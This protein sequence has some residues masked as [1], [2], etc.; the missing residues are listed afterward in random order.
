MA[1]QGVG[2][3]RRRT[4]AVAL[5]GVLGCGGAAAQ[6]VQLPEVTVNA[7]AAPETGGGPADGYVAH[8]SVAGTKTDTPLLET[9]QAISVVT[10]RQMDAQAVQTVDQALRYVPG[11]YSQDNDLRFEQVSIRGF[12]ADSYLDGL[13]LNHTTW[14]ATP[15]I[16]PWFLERIDVLHGPTSVLYGQGSPGGVIDMVSKLPTA[17]PLHVIEMG[18]GNHDRYQTGFD[19]GGPVD[20]DGK[21]LYRLT[22]LARD[23]NTQTDH[24]KEERYAIAPSLTW[25]PGADTSLTFLANYQNDPDGGLFNPVPAAGTVTHNPNGDLRPRQYL[26]DP[27]SDFFHRKQYSVGYQFQH[28]FNDHLQVRQNLRFLQDD[29][30]YYQ[31]SVTGPLAADFRTAPMW[32]NNNREQLRQFALD[33][34]AQFD[35]GTGPVQHTVLAGFDY[36]RLMQHI[37]RSGQLAGG[38]DVY[39]P[40]FSGFPHVPANIDQVTGQTQLG[41]Y[42]QDQLKLG[43]WALTVG[44]RRDW[45]RADD[46]Q[47]DAVTGA[48][49]TSSRQSDRAFTWRGGLS[50]LFDSGIAP[51]FSYS[52]SFQ[53]QLGSDF[54]GTPFIPTRGT[55]YEAGVKFQPADGNSFVTVAVYDLHQNNVLTPDPDHSFA[56][57][58]TGAIRSRGVEIEAHSNLTRE[59]SVIGSYA[60]MDQIVTR[61]NGVDQGK[62]PTAMPAQTA[63]GWAD[64]TMHSGDLAGLGFGGGV[65]YVGRSYGS[66]DNDLRLPSRWLADAAVHYE[67]GK[68]RLALNASNLFNQDYVAYCNSPSICYW[69][70][71]H[72]VMATARYQW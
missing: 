69:G 59:L 57:L 13:K 39:D 28:R 71:T 50:Y 49:T 40:D 12:A 18:I 25:R 1:V 16:D 53:P 15:R 22:G 61:S 54:G 6:V 44:G 17:E 34:Q 31:T 38:V 14:F 66:P 35:F 45:A 33:N 36:Q 30:D 42:M 55:Q 24:V 56:A 52:Q 37:H 29:I 20:Q 46:R 21:W 19:F 72:T 23:A 64:Y 63:S 70:A 48:Q 58:Q 9:P 2:R 68:W 60:Y 5:M 10:R 62:H 43:R 67:V 32:V 65:R 4:L 41:A 11:V 7:N 27:D 47:D 8:R 51:Y 26:G 3:F